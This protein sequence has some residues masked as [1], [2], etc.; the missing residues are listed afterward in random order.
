[1]PP[2][3][4]RVIDELNELAD[5]RN[6]LCAFIDNSPIFKSIPADEQERL[7]RQMRI[8][9]EYVAVLSERIAEFPALEGTR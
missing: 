2:H 4:Q 8:M 3:Q 1:M 5:R 6:K 9:G 7:K